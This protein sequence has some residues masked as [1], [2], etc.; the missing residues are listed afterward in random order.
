LEQWQPDVPVVD[1]TGVAAIV[2]RVKCGGDSALRRI[3][4]ELDD[5][6]PR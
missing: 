5:Q 3:A 4:L 1:V 6:P 2:D